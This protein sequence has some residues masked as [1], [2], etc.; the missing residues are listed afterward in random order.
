M[1]RIRDILTHPERVALKQVLHT[2]S[3]SRSIRKHHCRI[4]KKL[5]TGEPLHVLFLV[6]FPEMWNSEK[7]LFEELQRDSRFRTTLLCVPKYRELNQSGNVYEEE[8]CVLDFL[9]EKGYDAMDAR[10]GGSWVDI[11]SLKP[12]YI[13]LQRPY[14]SHLPKDY[15]F[16]TLR[17]YGLLCYVPYNGR[18][19]IGVYLKVEFNQ[20]F[21]KY[22]Y[23]FFADCI[24]SYRYV[25][26]WVDAR[27]FDGWKM[28]YN[29]GYP[30]YDMI[31]REKEK[32]PGKTTFLWLPRWS[33]GEHGEQ[34][35]KSHFL[36][37][38][39]PMLEYFSAH[40]ELELIIRPHPLMFMNFINKKVMTQAEVDDLKLKVQALPNVRFDENADYL[41]TIDDTDVL[42]SDASS[43][44]TEFFYTLR[45][46][47]YCD[48]LSDAT[49]NAWIM[50][51]SFYKAG[52]FKEIEKAMEQILDN[53]P[54]KACREDSLR[55]LGTYKENAAK[56]IKD[57]L[58][59]DEEL[60]KVPY[61]LW[62]EY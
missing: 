40:S 23:A 10:N 15:Q 48:E 43:L 19:N 28:I 45:P 62:G 29:L 12:D 38:V 2:S 34:D 21:L 57:A 8:N 61:S 56:N 5:R 44:V 18:F 41:E 6:Q 33:L 42:I 32:V 51:E 26:D 17:R 30:R 55:R 24:E 47:I 31:R 59:S 54:K 39:E 53:D 9:N 58:I 35:N 49:R 27:G 20:E 25:K 11:K 37:Y 50:H 14:S 3:V 60:K 7:A 4:I 46:I 36:E 52:S 22:F 1:K 13:F 16:K